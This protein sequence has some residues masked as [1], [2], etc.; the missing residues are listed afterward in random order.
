VL[1]LVSSIKY[2]VSCLRQ[3]GKYGILATKNMNIRY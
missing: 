3:A 1:N 2:R